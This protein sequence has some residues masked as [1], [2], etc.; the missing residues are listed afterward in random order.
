MSPQGQQL[1]QARAS[2]DFFSTELE[3]FFLLFLKDQKD[4]KKKKAPVK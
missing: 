1:K 3:I 4:E 2:T